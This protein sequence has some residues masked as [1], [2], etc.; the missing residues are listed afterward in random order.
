MSVYA[1]AKNAEEAGGGKSYLVALKDYIPAEA[2]AIYIF[3]VGFLSPAKDAKGADVAIITVFSLVVGLVASA[4][5][6][7]GSLTGDVSGNGFLR[8]RVSEKTRRRIVV[9]FVA[10]S[11]LVAYVLATLQP[12]GVEIATVDVARFLAVLAALWAV[13]LP[14]VASALGVRGDKATD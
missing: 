11:A 6:T 8:G 13:M 1:M 9:I 5:I 4:A 12:F 7:V 10:W 2:L 3:A 14:F